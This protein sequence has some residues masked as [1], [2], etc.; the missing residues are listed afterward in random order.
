M[1]SGPQRKLNHSLSMR[2]RSGARA[3]KGDPQNG[4]RTAD[5]LLHSGPQHGLNDFR[6]KYFPLRRAR[7][8][9]APQAGGRAT[10]NLIEKSKLFNLI[11][12]PT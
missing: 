12:G 10:R 7:R 11:L 6:S 3:T 8:T 5:L 2:F 1:D 4:L 9:G